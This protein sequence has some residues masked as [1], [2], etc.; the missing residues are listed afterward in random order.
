VAAGALGVAVC[1]L[2]AS[3]G[4]N[5]MSNVVSLWYLIAFS[6]AGAYVARTSAPDP[7]GRWAPPR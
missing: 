1:F 2:V 5:M 7:L 4:S 6:A 3:L